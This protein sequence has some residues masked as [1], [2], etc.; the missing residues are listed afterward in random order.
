[1]VDQPDNA[2]SVGNIVFDDNN[3]ERKPWKF[4][5][6]TF[7]RALVVFMCQYLVLFALIVTSVVRISRAKSCEENTAWVAILSSC[8]TYMFDPPRL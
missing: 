7:S 8:I 1:M 3:Q 4:F 6:R 2:L 5:G